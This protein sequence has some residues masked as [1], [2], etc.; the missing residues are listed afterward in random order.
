MTTS[1]R[2]LIAPGFLIVLGC[3]Q[4]AGDLLSL[5]KLKAIGIATSAS[6]APKVFT[7]HKGFETYSSYF[8]LR[9]TDASGQS[10][11][12]KLSPHLYAGVRGPYNRR[13]AYGAAL[14]YAP[15][16]HSSEHTRPMHGAVM[17]YT[18]CGKSTILKEI[19]VHRSEISGP[20]Q[21]ELRPR[22]RLPEG[23]SWKLSYTVTCDE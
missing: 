10:Q 12:V 6:P 1:Y 22:Q 15:V 3:L 2:P 13:N 4:M 16:L 19:G 21:F 17:H 23:H 14:S 7:A 20:I 11:E 8:Y 18:F 9:W 5:P